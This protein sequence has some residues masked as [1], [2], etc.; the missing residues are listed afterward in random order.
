[1]RSHNLTLDTQTDTHRR[2]HTD[3]HTLPRTRAYLCRRGLNYLHERLLL[4]RDLKTANIM[5]SKSGEVK[6][7]ARL[8]FLI[9]V[10]WC[11]C[12][13]ACLPVVPMTV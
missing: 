3:T 8:I 2:T 7:S 1:M 12:V 4:H 9:V 11:V 6:I 13:C 10:V 5:L